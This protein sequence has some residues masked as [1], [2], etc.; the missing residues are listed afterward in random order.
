[1]LDAEQSTWASASNYSMTSVIYDS[2]GNPHDL[3]FFF[4]KTAPNT[5]EYR[6]LGARSELDG[7]VTNSTELRQLGNGGTLRFNSNGSL[8]SALSSIMPISGMTWTNGAATQFIAAPV[9]ALTTQYARASTVIGVAQDG[10]PSGSLKSIDV[11][12]QGN[13][14]GLYSNG[15]LQ[16]L[17]TLQL[18]HFINPDD[19]SPIGESLFLPSAGSG[20]PQVGVAG[21]GGRGNIVAGALELSTVDLATEFVTML[22]S[23]RAFQVNSQVI[24]AAHEMYSIAAELKA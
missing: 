9:F 5:W 20:A 4:R 19:L 14:R 17:D 2:Q 12:A 11:D 16:I 8:N 6:V 15:T 1:M 13:I 24:T 22:S 7:S 23:Q 21:T 10:S 3:H 18:A